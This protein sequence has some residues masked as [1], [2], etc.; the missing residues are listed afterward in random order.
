MT[1]C[2]SA[3]DEMKVTP[4]CP[5]PCTV[6]SVTL[7]PPRAATRLHFS[8]QLQHIMWDELGWVVSAGFQLGSAWGFSDTKRLKVHGKV[9]GGCGRG[10][11]AG[12]GLHA[13]AHERHRR[14]HVLPP[15]GAQ[16]D[17]VS[18]V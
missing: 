3:P 8:A 17:I 13:P 10:P 1:E 18:K 14:R 6:A 9:D 12:L 4:V 7:P 11:A 2:V 16:V 15:V 5:M